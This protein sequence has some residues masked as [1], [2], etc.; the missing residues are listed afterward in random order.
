[1]KK[2]NTEKETRINGRFTVSLHS[3]AKGTD[4][5]LDLFF[6]VDLKEQVYHFFLPIEEF[7]KHIKGNSNKKIIL[8]FSAG[9]MHRKK[10][11][12]YEG[13]ISNNRGSLKI[14]R[15]GKFSILFST[16]DKYPTKKIKILWR[17]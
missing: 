8:E 10:Y 17:K 1:M 2:N 15:K 4:S 14:L 9:F 11:M 12:N 6:D 13:E 5:H 7:N 3:T 16:L